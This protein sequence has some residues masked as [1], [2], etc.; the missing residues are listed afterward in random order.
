MRIYERL[1]KYITKMAD[2]ELWIF[3]FRILDVWPGFGPIQLNS[4]MDLDWQRRDLQIGGFDSKCHAKL[5]KS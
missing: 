5:I 4:S 3:G 1:S 2:I